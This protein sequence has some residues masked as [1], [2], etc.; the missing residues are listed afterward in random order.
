MTGNVLRYVLTGKETEQFTT[1]RSFQRFTQLNTSM[2]E[3]HT[4]GH[5][6]RDRDEF[7]QILFSLDLECLAD[8]RRHPE[9]TRFPH[10][11]AS[12]LIRMLPEQGVQYEQ[13]GDRLGGF[14]EKE[15]LPVDPDR[16]SGWE[17][18]GFRR[19]AA[20]TE[21]ASFREGVKRLEN[22]AEDRT[23]AFMCAE[24]WYRKCHRQLIADQLKA[25][26]WTVHHIQSPTR[27]EVHEYRN[28][29]RVEEDRALYRDVNE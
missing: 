4:L 8:V 22:L 29:V 3:I 6:N 27:A 10:F 16:I 13:L 2:P 1:I 26:G 24:G 14:V 11:R 5:S 25:R 19:Y 9:S 21:S 17:A 12:N 15:E 7:L 28:V 23:T 20:Y 18:D